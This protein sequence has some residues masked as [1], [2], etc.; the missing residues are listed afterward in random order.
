ML[1]P[2]RLFPMSAIRRLTVPLILFAMTVGVC[3]KLLLTDQ[4]TYFDSPDLTS[5]VAPWIQAQAHAW[6]HRE[7]P[8]LWDPYIAGGQSL[9]GQ[10]QPATAYPPYWL[11]FLAPLRHGFIL[12][13]SLHWYM[14]LVHFVAALTCYALCR[15]LKRS[16]GASILAAAA[17][18]FGGYLGIMWWP[19]H[20]HAISWAP[21]TLMY[22][23]RAIRGERA[24][25]NTFFSGF[26]LGV[27]W[28]G[29]HH[30]I[31]TFT[32][33]AITGLWA[34]HAL[35]GKTA[36]LKIRRAIPFAVL[37]AAMVA[38]GALQL[39]PAYSYGHTAI[40]WAN[41]REPLHWNEPVPYSVHDQ[42]SQPP[43]AV[44]GLFIDGI[45]AHADPFIGF[46]VFLLAIAGV[47]L[48][49][50][51]PAVR[52]LAFMALGALLF[53]FAGAT[54]LHGVLYSIVPFV[55]KAR[56]PA[57]AIF[58]VQLGAC[59]LAAFGLD[60]ILE[61]PRSEW[62]KRAMMLSAASGFLLWMAAGFIAINKFQGDFRLVWMPLTALAA[63]LLAALLAALRQREPR[64]AAVWFIALV[65]LELGS[66]PGREMRN[67]DVGW[68]FWPVLE[69]DA[70]VAAFLKAQPGLFRID[71]KDDDVPYNFSDWYG[72][73]SYLGH[74]ASLPE[75]FTRVLGERTAYRLMGVRYYLARTPQNPDQHEVMTGANGLKVFEVPGAMPRAWSVHEA[76]TDLE[77]DVLPKFNAIDIQKT[78]ILHTPAPALESCADDRV[79]VSTH[80][81]QFVSIDAQ[82]NCRGMVILADAWSQDWVAKVDGAPARIYPAYTF[83]RGVVVGAGRH[84]VEFLYRPQSVM[85]GAALTFPAML[86]A[87]ALGLLRK[88]GR[89]EAGQV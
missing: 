66:Y 56:N 82:M 46:T 26:F 61:N 41:A 39:F 47:V 51:E 23:L 38:T 70:D 74:V 71:K 45:F 75:I 2:E 9:I 32:L 8:F 55:E 48:A 1:Y 86:V 13:G 52:L 69:R 20:V 84:R 12:I 60:R 54:L 16:R 89:T 28:L 36:S 77:P 79:E 57:V 78:T 4:Y 17:F 6:Q 5:Q 85:W 72:I 67:R 30:E 73:E 35:S 64:H 34:F 15:D 43:A 65:M 19:Q 29:G 11:L 53:S 10:A 88:Q 49:W 76:I 22:S 63:V 44:L 25:R 68:Q 7:F 40:R 81:A 42:F 50:E 58:L 62:V 18:S 27:E 37:I 59:P 87:L 80:K 83:L 3:W 14:A 21:L 31:P 24:L 33:L